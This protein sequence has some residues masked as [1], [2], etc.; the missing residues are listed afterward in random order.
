MSR[1]TPPARKVGSR[2]AE[3]SAS[4]ASE[5]SG[6]RNRSASA[7]SRCS[8]GRWVETPCTVAPAAVNSAN[9][10]RNVQDSSVHPFA[11]GIPAHPGG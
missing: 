4:P 8:S 1:L 3:V 7:N 11:P 6:K 5:R 9:W 10:S 2:S